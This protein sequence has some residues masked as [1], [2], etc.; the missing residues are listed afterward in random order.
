MVQHFSSCKLKLSEG[1][2]ERPEE[3][4]VYYIDYHK[5]FYN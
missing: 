2:T 4:I 1:H 3:T 5:L